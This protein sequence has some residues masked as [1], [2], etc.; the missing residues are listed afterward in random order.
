MH[1]CQRKHLYFTEHQKQ[2]EEKKL[3]SGGSV[4]KLLRET[5]Q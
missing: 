2:S 4:F 1:R 5:Y 3:C